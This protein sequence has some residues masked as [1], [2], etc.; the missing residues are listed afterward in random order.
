MVIGVVVRDVIES[1][2]DLKVVLLLLFFCVLL[3]E[4]WGLMF[5]ILSYIEDRFLFI[6]VKFCISFKF[7]I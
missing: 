3:V 6:V 4:V 7:C 5:K 1:V 2:F